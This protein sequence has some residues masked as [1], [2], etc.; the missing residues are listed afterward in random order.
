M[1][2]RPLKAKRKSEEEIRAIQNIRTQAAIA[3]LKM[4]GA[5]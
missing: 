2:S 3:G 4:E 1:A 5:M